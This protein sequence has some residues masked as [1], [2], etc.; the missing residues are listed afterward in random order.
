MN[1]VSKSVQSKKAR[2]LE[3][4]DALEIIKPKRSA[5]ASPV[6][7]LCSL[8]LQTGGPMP[9]E[10]RRWLDSYL[11]SERKKIKS[12]RAFRMWN[13]EVVLCR[14]RAKKAATG[15]GKQSRVIAEYASALSLDESTVRKWRRSKFYA[16][17][18]AISAHM[19]N[20]IKEVLGK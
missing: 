8:Y 12:G 14:A 3:L 18:L 20:H 16:A 5:E 19:N 4:S 11:L 17:V 6:L 7:A 9:P 1:A 10:L 15:K 13:L 2:E